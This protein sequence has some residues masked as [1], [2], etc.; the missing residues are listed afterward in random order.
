MKMEEAIEQ[1]K[2]LGKIYGVQHISDFYAGTVRITKDRLKMQ[3]GFPAEEVLKNPKSIAISIKDYKLIPLI[4]WIKPH[5]GKKN[6]EG[7]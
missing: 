1:M 6:I 7:K 3:L 5:T 4:V 2:L